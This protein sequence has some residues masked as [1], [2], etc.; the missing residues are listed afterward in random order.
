MARRPMLDTDVVIDYLRKQPSAL[1]FIR[2][3]TVRPMISAITVGE[4]YSGVRDGKERD[5]L[6]RLS[7]A[8]RVI[9]LSRAMAAQGGLHRRQFGPSHGVQLS[10]ALIAATVEAVQGELFTLNIKHFPML[11]DVRVPYVKA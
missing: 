3:L 2:G 11:S 4:L 9:P 6:E 5:A 10:D 8:F 7:I 1:S